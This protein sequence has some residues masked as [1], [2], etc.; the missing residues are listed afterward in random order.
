M[1]QPRSITRHVI[2]AG[3]AALTA[4]LLGA[5]AL[6]GS[7]TEPAGMGPTEARAAVARLLPPNTADRA[8]WAAD[9]HA[10]LATLALPS[11]PHNLCAVMA[12][13]EQE[14]GYRADPAV[15]GL[16]AIAWKEIDR[17]ADAAGV[18]QLAVRA[19]LALTSPDGRSY[20]ERI[21]AVKTERQLS[22]IFEDFI[23]MV[24]L[25]KTFFASRNPVRTGGPMQVSIAFAEA[26]VQARPYPYPVRESVR[27]E[28]FTRRGGLYFG[29]AH[30]LAY[31]AP[32][33]QPI[34]RFADFNAGRW[35]S[36]NAAFQQALG[37][38]SGL[39]LALDGD[40]LPRASDA[41]AGETERAARTLAARLGL[42]EAAIRR[43]LAQGD[44]AGFE[45]S[46]LYERVFAYAEKLERKTLPRAV[47]PRI[48]LHSPKLTRRLTTEWFAR[49][50]DERHRRCLERMAPPD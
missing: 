30:L 45:R 1:A 37:V 39:S 11:T 24:P 2:T 15:P 44:D 22:E 29:T 40:L 17:R 14:S 50:V 6:P 23:G 16:P 42:T 9:I 34:Y 43:D 41:P 19:A 28:V 3:L 4:A 36:R 5:C 8:G 46:A 26:H 35:A 27:R 32:Y 47:L 20:A 13:V 49:R 18:P 48:D 25:G 21:D 7:V 38:A 12:V 33:R 31:E 10:A